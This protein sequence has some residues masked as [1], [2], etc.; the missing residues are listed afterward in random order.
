MIGSFLIEF[1]EG[2]KKPVRK[3][4]EPSSQPLDNPL[5]DILPKPQTMVIEEPVMPARKALVRHCLDPGLAS[6][7]SYFSYQDHR[8]IVKRLVSVG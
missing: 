1:L 2:R 7:H 4:Q 5:E 6:F 3:E 8:D